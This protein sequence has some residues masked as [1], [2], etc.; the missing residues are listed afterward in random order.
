M[1]ARLEGHGLHSGAPGAVRFERH[2]GPT[3][4]RARGVESRVVDLRVVDTTRSTT[5]ED[6]SG[7]VRIGTIEHVLAALGGLGLHSG[8]AVT[9][10]GTEPP[11]ADGGARR[12]CDLARALAVPPSPAP[13]RVVRAG[14]LEHGG[15][16]YELACAEGDAVTLEVSIDFDDARIARSAHWKGDPDD[17]RERIA[18]ARTFGFEHE[19]GDLLERGLASHVTPESVVVIGEGRV[20]SSGAPFTA[21]EPVRH[22]LLDL[23]G[24]LF[25]YGGPPRGILRVTR[26]GHAATH[27]VMTRALAEGL[28]VRD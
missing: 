16:R 19:V 28:V 20:L 18:V 1:N 3:V 13:L 23:V 7:N 11:L 12:Y 6:A 24:D 8:V 17:F 14:V 21:D 9:V 4:L 10:E 5:V 2:D 26:P 27:A 25:L 22:K 15:S